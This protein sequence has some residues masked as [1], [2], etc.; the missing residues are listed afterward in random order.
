[1]VLAL[2]RLR[3]C[4]INLLGE[5]ERR[6]YDG[7]PVFQM[8]L[9]SPLNPRPRASNARLGMF[10]TLLILLAVGMAF[11]RTEGFEWFVLKN[12]IRAKYPN[13]RR[14]ATAQLDDWLADPQ[15][16]TP[17]LVDVR[18]EPEW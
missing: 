1:M 15:R 13:V 8:E 9:I 10:M 12:A 2:L 17:V 5:I 11:A 3:C 14:I 18:T 7:P 6:N 16:E 4:D